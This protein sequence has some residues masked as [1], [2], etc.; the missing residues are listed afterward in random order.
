[1]LLTEVSGHDVI[2]PFFSSGDE[3]TQ[4]ASSSSSTQLFRLRPSASPANQTVPLLRK[5]ARK[6]QSGGIGTGRTIQRQNA[7]DEQS[8]KSPGANDDGGGTE[9]TTAT[10]VVR[11][12][13]FPLGIVNCSFSPP[14]SLRCSLRAAHPS[15]VARQHSSVSRRYIKALGLSI[16]S[17]TRC[18]SIW[19]PSEL[20]IWS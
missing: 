15:R 6:R 2:K 12:L 11:D 9:G 1:V 19:T 16:H 3:T 14:R 17:R 5:P 18:A 4:L 8:G 13:H 7:G 10:C 20:V